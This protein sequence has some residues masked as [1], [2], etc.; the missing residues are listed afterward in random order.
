MKREI[1]NIVVFSLL[2]LFVL[3]LGGYHHFRFYADLGEFF[4]F[5]NAYDEDTYMLWY[6]QWRVAPS[7]VFSAVLYHSLKNLFPKTWVPLI[8]EMLW[9][10]LLV[11]VVYFT[12]LKLTKRYFLSCFFSIL[13]L[14]APDFLS[15]QNQV[16]YDGKTL[17][18]FIGES[19]FLKTYIPY[20]YTTFLGFQRNHE[21]ISSWLFYTFFF[22]LMVLNYKERGFFFDYSRKKYIIFA[23]L[24]ILSVFTYTFL[25]V[26]FIIFLLLFTISMAFLKQKKEFLSGGIL[27]IITLFGFSVSSYF[28]PPQGST[29][30]YNS[31]LPF[32][33]LSLLPLPLFLLFALSFIRKK[34]N[35]LKVLVITT[36]LFLIPWILLNQQVVTGH[37]ISVRDWEKYSCFFYLSVGGL[38]G[39]LLFDWSKKSFLFAKLLLP[40]LLIVS[41]VSLFKALRTS[42]QM[43]YPYNLT[44]YSYT[45]IIEKNNVNESVKEPFI[46]LDKPNGAPFLRWYFNFPSDFFVL[47][48]TELF[49][50]PIGLLKH[51]NPPIN[52]S[53]HRQRLFNY[54]K[55]A[56]KSEEDVNKLLLTQYEGFVGF[57]IN[58]LFS[59]MDSWFPISDSRYQRVENM[60]D[61][62]LE[63]SQDYSQ[64]EFTPPN[65]K[66]LIRI[67]RLE[68]IV[69]NKD[70]TF[71]SYGL[72]ISNL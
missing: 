71:G 14:C 23:L 43:W 7:R 19:I 8:M 4:Y 33:S 70:L 54:F 3:F 24:S 22:S 59:F 62:V 51:N 21:P 53:Y 48:Y 64:F 15:L 63:Q 55:L 58:F 68:T 12:S 47:D 52:Q 72:Q 56:N 66:R 67:Q 17:G 44:L 34:K 46:F 37:L 30:I 49:E 2:I 5:K 20:A 42:Y 18:Y 69:G 29:I 45:K 40:V 57:H 10:C 41:C 50:R 6:E 11:S 60:R 28:Q 9:P 26:P 13:F 36:I 39:L 31:H 25:L 35:A 65:G 1:L 32:L 16:M 27:A 38:C 61:L